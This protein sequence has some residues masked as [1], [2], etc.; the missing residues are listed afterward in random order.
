MKKLITTIALIASAFS[1]SASAD[2]G[3]VTVSVGLI[4]GHGQMKIFKDMDSEINDTPKSI[5]ISYQ[6][7]ESENGRWEHHIGAGV[8]DQSYGNA[9][10]AK[11]I[12]EVGY[13]MKYKATQ[14]LKLTVDAGWSG[15][16]SQY[17]F[18]EGDQEFYIE[19]GATNAGMLMAAVGVE[20]QVTENIS[21]GVKAAPTYKIDS[22]FNDCWNAETEEWT[23][24][25]KSLD[26]AY[27]GQVHIKL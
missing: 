16:E 7:A 25:A 26:V 14:D 22:N 2:V 6:V 8:R 9:E 11:M 5:H 18:K 24:P 15:Y 19:T 13:T 3:D 27:L 1:F 12:P 10:N 21:V 23:D 17:N 20:Y 4:Q